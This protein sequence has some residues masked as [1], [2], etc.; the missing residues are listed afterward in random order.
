MEVRKEN[1]RNVILELEVNVNNLCKKVYQKDFKKNSKSKNLISER[2]FSILYLISR[3]K[4]NTTSTIADELSLSRS[5]ISIIVSK[6]ETLGYVEKH[7]SDVEGDGRN[8]FFEITKNGEKILRKQI[9]LLEEHFFSK[10]KSQNNKEIALEIIEIG[11]LFGVVYKIKGKVNRFDNLILIILKITQYFDRKSEMAIS[12]LDFDLSVNE[13]KLLGMLDLGVNT[14][15]ELS[16]NSGTTSSALSTQISNLMEKGYVDK[17]VDSNDKRRKYLYLTDNA[18]K[19]IKEIRKELTN[20]IISDIET[21][22][23]EEQVVIYTIIDKIDNVVK[24]MLKE[25]E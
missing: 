7:Q 14:I 20:S 4:I 19:A 16:E 11:K 9:R 2:Q 23:K 3:K 21:Y 25:L 18:I 5:N 24:L 12:T 10:L 22:D 8:V 6:L 1:L 17:I 15:E 13:S